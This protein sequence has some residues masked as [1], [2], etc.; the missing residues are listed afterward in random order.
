LKYQAVIFDLFGTL[1]VFSLANWQDSIQ[2]MAAALG[3][4]AGAFLRGWLE[5]YPERS[6]GSSASLADYLTL[7]CGH[8]GLSPASDR[9]AEA[10]QIRKDFTRRTLVLRDD[11]ETTLQKLKSAGLKIGLVSNCTMEAPG[12]WRAMP[13]ARKVDAA[14]F[15]S[16][17]GLLKP[18]P[19]MYN[20]VTRRLGVAPNKCLY[21]G[22]GDSDELNGAARVGMHPVLIR[23]PKEDMSRPQR[24]V[25]ENWAGRI[26]DDLTE[27]VGLTG[28]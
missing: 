4:E 8:L 13:I 3:A 14:I 21:V 18:H 26:I 2:R 20:L 16:E 15:S 24:A 28:E 9:I 25:V 6:S 5:S 1:V 12:L 7:L 10:V 17:V 27:V 23:T 19:E 22:D 11:A